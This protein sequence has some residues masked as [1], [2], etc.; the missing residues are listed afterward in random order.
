MAFFLAQIVF[1]PNFLVQIRDQ[2]PKVDPCAKFHQPNWTENKRA[3][4]ST[5][6]DT[7]NCLMTSYSRQVMT[8]AKFLMFLREFVPEYHH[9][10]SE[11]NWTANN[12]KFQF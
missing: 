7:E 4:I 10:K 9:T 3:R 1:I 2:C 11:G 5:W 12:E 8:S 6:I